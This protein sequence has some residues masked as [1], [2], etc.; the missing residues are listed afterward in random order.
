MENIGT[1]Q[2]KREMPPTCKVCG[3]ILASKKEQ[4]A[5][6]KKDHGL[7]T[8]A[9]RSSLGSSIA[10]LALRGFLGNVMIMHGLPLLGK[11]KEETIQEMKELGVPKEATLSGSLLEVVGGA[12]LLAGFMT[13]VVSSLFVAEMI[14]T[15]IL[16]KEKMGKQF[17]SDGEKPSYELDAMY[18]VAFSVLAVIG[19]GDFSVDRLIG[20]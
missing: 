6:R 20:L 5:H 11:K 4:S 14:G 16:S 2:E 8:P 18:L 7:I 15:T 1:P 12:S 9:G 17:L 10:S 19:G 3:K 13:P